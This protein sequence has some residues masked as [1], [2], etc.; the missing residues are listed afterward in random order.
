M[1]A[2]HRTHRPHIKVGKD[3]GEKMYVAQTDVS[4]WLPLVLDGI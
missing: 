1:E 4:M 2:S 3:A